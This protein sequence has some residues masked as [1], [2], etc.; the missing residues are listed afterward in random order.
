MTTDVLRLQGDYLIVTKN[1]SGRSAGGALTLDVGGQQLTQTNTGTVYINGDLVVTGNTIFGNVSNVVV[2]DTKITDNI[3][4]LNA[5][6]NTNAL[7]GAV[8]RGTSGIKISRGKLGQDL[9]QFAAFLEWND[10]K[11]WQ[12]TG[13]ISNIQGIWEFR[14]GKSGRP[15]YSAI[16]VN[17]I[18]IDEA[19]ASTAG[20]GAGQGSRL[21]I[22]GSDNPTAVMSVSGTNNYESRVT[23]PDDIPN[24]AY[25]DNLLVTVQPTANKLVVGNSYAT[26]KDLYNDGVTS[27]FFVVL[28]GN[29]AERLTVTTGTTVLRL[30]PNVA[31][32]QGVQFVANE[33]S[34]IG[35]NQN[36][37]LTANGTGQIVF[38]APILFET[39]GIPDPDLGQTGLYVA[40][41]GGGGTGVFFVS[42]DNLGVTTTDEFTSRK[43]A[44]VYAIIFG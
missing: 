39:G 25:V 4:T 41:P 7:T 2:E 12:G 34:P 6:E 40:A 14:V 38:Q 37:L 28:N 30:T 27:E 32:F 20:A 26:I 5:G 22:F 9:D 8:T 36:L 16:K 43:R 17:A 18:R 10:T 44:L 35:V 3:L 15:Q 29:P 21:S 19:S 42:K 33:I 24:K 11:S 1:V 31:Q 13:A 23:D